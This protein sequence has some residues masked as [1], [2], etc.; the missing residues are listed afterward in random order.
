MTTAQPSSR[1]IT[2]KLT[3]LIFGAN[4]SGALIIFV[5]LSVI[6]PLPVG[7]AGGPRA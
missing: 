3:A 1:D 7:G 2:R 6:D 5:F 4:F